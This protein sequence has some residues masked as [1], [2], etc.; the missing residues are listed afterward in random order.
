MNESSR[1]TGR[2]WVEL[3]E[4][5]GGRSAPPR[6]ERF[7]RFLAELQDQP[8]GEQLAALMQ[9]I[10]E[11]RV[12]ERP[13]RETAAVP[14]LAAARAAQPESV[15][16]AEPRVVPARWWRRTTLELLVVFALV[17]ATEYAL[18]GGPGRIGMQPH[19][20][21]LLVVA[22]AGARGAVAALLAGGAA[23]VL[24]AI[25]LWQTAVFERW[26]DLLDL[27][28]LQEPVLFM[29]VGFVLGNLRDAL[30][31]RH[32]TLCAR[33]DVVREQR[34]QL[35]AEQKLLVRVNSEL[36]RRLFDQST[37]FGNLIETLTKGETGTDAN[38]YELALDM[39][40]EHCGATR[41]SLLLVI[42]EWTLDLAAHRGWTQGN[43][44][45]LLDE[46]LTSQQVQRAIQ[47]AERVSCFSPGEPPAWLGP[48][49]VAPIADGN[50]VVMALLCLDELPVSRLNEATVSTFW[51]IADWLEARLEQIAAQRRPIDVRAALA[52]LAGAEPWLG[53]AAELGA[54]I[55]LE[56]AR[57][58]RHGI[59]TALIAV[60]AFDFDVEDPAIKTHLD[61]FFRK[62]F[63][64]DLRACDYVYSFGY[65]GCYVVVLAG[66]TTDGAEIVRERLDRRL[67]GL[68]ADVIGRVSVRAFAPTEDA[69]RLEGLLEEIAA[70][71]RAHS[72]V[73]LRRECP[74]VVPELTVV[75]NAV[76]FELRMRLEILLARRYGKELSLIDIRTGDVHQGARTVAR[77]LSDGSVSL[78]RATDGIYATG[79]NRCAVV[80]PATSCDFAF[81]L[82]QRLVDF[83]Q[84][85]LPEARFAQIEMEVMA[86][87]LD[88]P[89]ELLGSLVRSHMDMRGQ[90]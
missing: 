72:I 24:Y 36:K 56:D 37:Q 22:V 14:V 48:L 18:C 16:A 11:L 76:D 42:E 12:A 33:Y 28:H 53:S 54:R 3:E 74:V 66:T 2:G 52:N 34:D 82:W 71:F 30:A 1:H 10:D 17:A 75:G 58:G 5:D 65:L 77:H 47:D 88:D 19:P 63:A 83:L 32:D 55:R 60:Q 40:V 27:Q 84:Q 78:L 51:G 61:G 67:A 8:G 4:L 41:C 68:V 35:L 46:A 39:I 26:V 57:C 64:R 44:K 73:P 7:E 90:S 59:H 6:D 89:E 43:I 79:E 38:A 31:V 81:M 50:G 15:A 25:G 45:R 29:A 70:H 80:L 87:D 49:V 62:A 13:A 69:P 86:L 20:Y 9:D 85:R 23:A 21:W